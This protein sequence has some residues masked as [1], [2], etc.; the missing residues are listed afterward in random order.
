[1]KNIFTTIL[2]ALSCSIMLSCS[3][4]T[5]TTDESK[6]VMVIHGGAGTIEKSS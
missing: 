6:Y 1:M 3:D 4:K 5:A 2:F